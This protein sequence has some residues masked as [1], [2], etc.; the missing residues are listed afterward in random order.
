MPNSRSTSRAAALL[1]AFVLCLSALHAAA[2][3][4]GKL[5]H[6][7][8]P[9]AAGGVQDLL[10]RSISDDL[11]RALGQTVVVENRPGAGGTVGTGV[12]ARATPDGQTVVMA[13]ASHLIAPYLYAKL[14]YDPQKDFVP[15]A[16]IGIASYILMI[17]ASVPASSTGEFIKYAK[18]NPG[19]L[20]YASAG[21]GSATHL[22]MAYFSGLAGIDIV[23]IPYKATGEAINE[24]IAGRAQAV[25]AANIG[26]LG[27]KDDKRVKL[28]GVTSKERSRF[29]PDLPTL[30]ESGLPNYEFTSWFGL[31]AP[32]GT[33]KSAT[34]AINAA[35][36][37][38]LKDP[39]IQERLGRQG[40]EFAAMP[41]ADFGRLLGSESEKM[42]QVVK[43]AGLKP[44]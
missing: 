11:G 37:K 30:A 33:P 9:F 29:V 2:Q 15:A 21:N 20:N 4:S 26:A 38:L 39:S 22:A 36:D 6:I 7:I 19:K 12:V 43:L 10:A 17:P 35:V 23:H 8:V 5:F 31:L 13:A 24:V 1:T 14:G 27:F 42:A 44:E 41:N 34:D 25:I 32:A 3:T 28:L 40:I 16:Y 18:A